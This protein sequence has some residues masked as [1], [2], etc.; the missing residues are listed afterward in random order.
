MGY[1][2]TA[3]KWRPQDFDRLIG[4][5]FVKDTL[6]NSIENGRIANAYLF[7]G[8][9]GVGKTS[10]AR[11]L[12]KALNCENGPTATPC[13]QCRNCREIT[14]GNAIDVMEIDGASNT[15]VENV[16]QIRDEILFAPGNSRYK[17]YIIDEVHMLSNSAFNALLKTIEEPPPYIVFMFATTEVHKV[18]P[19]IRSRC[20]QFNFVLINPVTIMQNLA[21]VL[22]DLKIAYDKDALLWISKEG[23]G[24][25][26]D[27]YTLLDQIIS[28]S[29]DRISMDLINEKLG[30]VKNEQIELL[31]QSI[32]DKKTGRVLEIISEILDSGVSLERFNIDL[33]EF[34]R[35]L[36][37]LK[38]G[39]DKEYIL[40]ISRDNFPGQFIE[41]FEIKQLVQILDILFEY[42][43][44]IKFSLNPHY[45]MEMILLKLIN[46]TNFITPHDVIERMETLQDQIKSVQGLEL[47]E[48]NINSSSVQKENTNIDADSV[49]DNVSSE[50]S[51]N[52]KKDNIEFES[53][54]D[55]KNNHV[56]KNILAELRKN[57]IFLA[58]AFESI[59]AM[60]MNY[61][62]IRFYFSDNDRHNYESVQRESGLI[63][64]IIEKVCSKKYIITCLIK[65]SEKKNLSEFEMKKQLIKD[66]FKG[67]VI[68]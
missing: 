32:I 37:L 59:S 45:E 2:N 49:N 5:D 57:K 27:A 24:S 44:R 18:I 50:E 3:N 65:E 17:I 64:S 22:T 48:Q 52:L 38:S 51:G 54:A 13:N 9:R 40:G 62:K 30:L 60:Q 11:I 55:F 41:F 7:S 21:R 6:T 10:V 58:N 47:K 1:V 25:L 20:Q 39:I 19:T 15:S 8:P 23:K 16:R 34:F 68:K 67:D 61:E 46:Y 26:R 63:S 12:A 29:G 35:N 33:I 53:I 4:Q 66:I 42:S 36:L 31:I 14:K 56:Y 28:F 43:R